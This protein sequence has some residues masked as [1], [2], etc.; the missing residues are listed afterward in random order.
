MALKETFAR[1]VRET[2]KLRGMTQV[3]LAARLGMAQADLCNLE[4]GKRAPTLTTVE[5]IAVALDVEPT[6]LLTSASVLQESN[7]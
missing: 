4:K 1:R 3:S 2:R 6:F 7:S 5:K